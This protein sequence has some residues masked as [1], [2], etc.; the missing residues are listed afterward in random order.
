MRLYIKAWYFYE[1]N[2][3][4]ISLFCIHL[5]SSWF[6]VSNMNFSLK[7]KGENTSINIVE[8][9]VNN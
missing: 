4:F 7:I 3:I 5:L 1:K 6:V 2:V 9:G 8:A